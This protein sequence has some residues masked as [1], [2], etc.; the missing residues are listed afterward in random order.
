MKTD[1]EEEEERRRYS[2]ARQR[3]ETTSLRLGKSYMYT[4][5]YQVC[6]LFLAIVDGKKSE[7]IE[8]FTQL[9]AVGTTPIPEFAEWINK[10]TSFLIPSPP[11][12]PRKCP[13]YGT[14]RPREKDNIDREWNL[15]MNSIL[16]AYCATNTPTYQNKYVLLTQAQL[17]GVTLDISMQ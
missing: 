6:R 14:P 2:L 17:F 9:L 7:A 4:Y 15:L 11:L 12:L 13:F 16:F 3:A 1:D 8:L 5:E 10:G